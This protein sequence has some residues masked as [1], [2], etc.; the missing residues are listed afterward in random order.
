MGKIGR[1][2]KRYICRCVRTGISGHSHRHKD[3]KGEYLKCEECGRKH[4]TGR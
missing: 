3:G 1:K 2:K 4:Y